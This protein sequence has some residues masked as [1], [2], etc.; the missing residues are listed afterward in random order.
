MET[1]WCMVRRKACWT[2]SRSPSNYVKY[3]KK[4]PSNSALIQSGSYFENFQ[5]I[6]VSV[7]WSP[8][9]RVSNINKPRARY[10]I[11]FS[12]ESI[13]WNW[14]SIIAFFSENS[15][16]WN[17]AIS[18]RL[19]ETSYAIIDMNDSGIPDVYFFR[20]FM[21]FEPLLHRKPCKF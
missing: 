17:D 1:R 12:F 2:K 21:S 13:H 14:E 9:D 10:E 3:E 20:Y 5:Q 19:I 16:Y 18:D 15:E 4:F 6:I 11:I 7:Q 8:I